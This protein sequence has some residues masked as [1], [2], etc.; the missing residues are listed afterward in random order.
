MLVASCVHGESKMVHKVRG[1]HHDRNQK[2]TREGLCAVAQWKGIF[3]AHGRS[4]V[5]TVASPGKRDLAAGDMKD[6]MRATSSLHR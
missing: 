5:Q 6:T 1:S 4:Q 2:P 3:L